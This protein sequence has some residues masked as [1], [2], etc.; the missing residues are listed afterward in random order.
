MTR[1]KY[2]A[3]P[4]TDHYHN[5][6][7]PAQEPGSGGVTV[8]GSQGGSVSGATELLVAGSVAEGTPGQAV[9]TLVVQM[10]GPFPFTF[11][12]PLDLDGS[13]H[14]LLELDEGSVVLRSW[15][16]FTEDFDVA[17]Q[18]IQISVLSGGSHQRQAVLARYPGVGVTA[19]TDNEWFTRELATFGDVDALSGPH[20]SFGAPIVMARVGA[21]LVATYEQFTPT[22]GACDVYAIIAT[23]AS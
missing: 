22:E 12:S 21:L 18:F 23:P 19:N 15:A 13:W 2:Q 8:T 17:D 20:G 4:A 3:G 1:T 6:L 7:G 11:D 5:A 16:I 9:Q 10:L 14:T